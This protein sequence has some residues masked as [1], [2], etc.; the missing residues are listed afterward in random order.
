MQ[1]DACFGLGMSQIWCGEL[2][3]FLIFGYKNSDLKVSVLI[4]CKM[5]KIKYTQS[6]MDYIVLDLN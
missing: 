1:I 3:L 2:C 4:P 5:R 6:C